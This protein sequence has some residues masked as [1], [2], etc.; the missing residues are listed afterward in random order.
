[1]RKRVSKDLPL[2]IGDLRD[3]NAA[4]SSWIVVHAAKNPCHS[5]KC[6]HQTP[7]QPNYLHFQEGSNLWLNLIDAPTPDL[8]PKAIFTTF[9]AFAKAQWDG[10]RTMLI[11]CNQGN[12]RAPALAILFLAKVLYR[13]RD[14]SFDDAGWTSRSWS[15][16][17]SLQAKGSNS[18]LRE[19][20][21]E[22]DLEKREAPKPSGPQV[23]RD[24][25]RAKFLALTPAAAN[26]FIRT[27]P[28]FHFGM[29]QILLADH[30]W[31][32]P[33]AN[34]LQREMARV[35]DWCISHEQKCR[36]IVLKPRKVGCSTFSAELC[37]HHMRRF[38]ANMLLLGDVAKRCESVFQ[39]FCSI[40]E[41]ELDRCLGQ[42]VRE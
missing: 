30:T 10:E 12:S 27:Q 9:L 8:F 36:M 20:W 4:D 24:A 42:Q 19:H 40:H 17:S 37:Y 7:E 1:M 5:T 25:I 13:I 26:E 11:H 34:L 2:Y 22:L 21:R 3:C 35:Y 33:T 18:W 39:T 16:S 15:A 32:A 41:R 38:Q 6:G 23:D 29:T 14:T 31:G 28:L